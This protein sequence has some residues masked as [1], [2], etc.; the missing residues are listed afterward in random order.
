MYIPAPDV[1][2]SR[3]PGAARELTTRKAYTAASAVCV[4][5]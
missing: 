1:R 4:C 3:P 5:V 2:M